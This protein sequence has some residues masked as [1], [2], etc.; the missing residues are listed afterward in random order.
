MRPT[1]AGWSSERLQVLDL[2]GPMK[3]PGKL[4]GPIPNAVGCMTAL[5]KK[6]SMSRNNLSGSIPHAVGSMTAL[7]ELR[8]RVCTNRFEDSR[9]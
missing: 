3:Q 9:A 7:E 5:T 1:N 6:L 2:S 4:S 8:K